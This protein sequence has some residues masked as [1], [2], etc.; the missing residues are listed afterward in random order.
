MQSGIH[1]NLDELNAAELMALMI[2]EHEVNRF[3]KEQA[4]KR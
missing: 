3:E 4:E 1:V 2:I